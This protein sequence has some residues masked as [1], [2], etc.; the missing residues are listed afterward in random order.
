[1]FKIFIISLLLCAV[2]SIFN[3]ET[4]GLYLKNHMKLML[5]ENSAQPHILNF[6]DG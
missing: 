2:V 1:M 6:I 3:C 4:I 5:L